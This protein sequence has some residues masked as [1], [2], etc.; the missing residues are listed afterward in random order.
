M[1]YYRIESKHNNKQIRA[2][3]DW[4]KTDRSEDLL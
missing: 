2:T 1:I 4:I 3:I